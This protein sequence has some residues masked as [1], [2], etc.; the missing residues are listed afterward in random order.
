MNYTGFVCL[1]PPFDGSAAH[2][3][4]IFHFLTASV[5]LDISAATR[6]AAQIPDLRTAS[7]CR[8]RC[9]DI[10]LVEFELAKVTCLIT[11]TITAIKVTGG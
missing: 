4:R 9:A 8:N 3:Q 6:S 10:P 5:S 1:L 7:A 2:L 11:R